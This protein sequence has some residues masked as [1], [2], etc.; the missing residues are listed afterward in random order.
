MSNGELEREIFDLVQAQIGEWSAFATA[1]AF[2]AA[3][4]DA[5]AQFGRPDAAIMKWSPRPGHTRA[6]FRI[7]R[8]MDD[9][10]SRHR[11]NGGPTSSSRAR[12]RQ[13]FVQ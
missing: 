13:Q 1:D 4:A 3:A 9:W 7:T 2:V 10:R 6:A 8:V 5:W 12:A 11:G